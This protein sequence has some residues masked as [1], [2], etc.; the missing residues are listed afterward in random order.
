M[1][2]TGIP[3]GFFTE[4]FTAYK[5]QIAPEY[6]QACVRSCPR[7]VDYNSDSALLPSPPFPWDEGLQHAGVHT[8]PGPS[9]QWP[10]PAFGHAV[11]SLESEP[12]IGLLTP[13]NAQYTGFNAPPSPRAP[14]IAGWVPPLVAEST[15]SAGPSNGPWPLPNCISVEKS[16]GSSPTFP[17]SLGGSA[18]PSIPYTAY[19]GYSRPFVAQSV[20]SED[21]LFAVNNQFLYPS[22]VSNEGGNYLDLS[23]V[24]VNRQITSSSDLSE[25][26]IIKKKLISG[27]PTGP[28]QSSTSGDG[29]RNDIPHT[30][31]IQRDATNGEGGPSLG[32]GKGKGKRKRM[33]EDS[34]ENV[35]DEKQYPKR[36]RRHDQ[37][38]PE[39]IMGDQPPQ[40]TRQVVEHEKLMKQ[41][42]P[43]RRTAPTQ[44]NA[45]PFFEVTGSTD[46]GG[47]A[48]MK[49]NKCLEMSEP[50]AH[51]PVVPPVSTHSYQQTIH[52]TKEITLNG[53]YIGVG[54]VPLNRKERAALER[55]AGIRKA[56]RKRTKRNKKQDQAP[57]PSN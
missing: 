28:G 3:Y 5:Q 54:C 7:T 36:A 1:D 40:M 29:A 47:D 19:D 11:G 32:K 26:G 57:R 35:P 51:T 9:I 56:V 18:P 46:S 39:R 44:P 8:S 16:W 30:L 25:E 13:P 38:E 49:K 17:S 10:L 15:Y 20:Y 22:P 41:R 42:G 23:S 27:L 34:L 31:R 48:K 37:Q 2:Y 52:G 4:E 43:R 21:S 50:L 24:N 45:L 53:I 6:H 12:A 33:A 14:C 55:K